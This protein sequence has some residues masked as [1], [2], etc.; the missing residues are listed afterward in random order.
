MKQ[1]QIIAICDIEYADTES[2]EALRAGDR[3]IQ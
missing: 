1:K 3:A 2:D